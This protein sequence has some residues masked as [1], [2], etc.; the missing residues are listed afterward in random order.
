MKLDFPS[1]SLLGLFLVCLVGVTHGISSCTQSDS[2]TCKSDTGGVIDLKPLAK[3]DNTPK[4]KDVDS[5]T[6]GQ[7]YS[8]N[9]CYGFDEGACSGVASC[10][11]VGS[12]SYFDAGTPTTAT[13][14]VEKGSDLKQLA[15]M[16]I[17]DD[18]LVTITYTSSDITRQTKVILICEGTEKFSVDALLTN[19]DTTYQWLYIYVLRAPQA[20]PGGGGGLSAGSILCIVF[21]SFLV[22]YLLIGFIVT[23]FVQ[24]KEGKERIPN[25]H[26]WFALPIMVKDGTVF[27]ISKIPGIGAKTQGYKYDNI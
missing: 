2:C 16:D 20:C 9:P 23:T 14:A 1:M 19:P 17:P 27:V 5:P 15:P 12:N 26:F 11:N 21:V 13:F 18:N 8:Y 10:E 4:Y 6:A 25:S 24:K 22:L 7:Q 3:N